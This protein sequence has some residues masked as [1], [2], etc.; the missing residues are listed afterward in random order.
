[1][2]EPEIFDYIPAGQPYDF[3][4][5][6]F[7]KLLE[8]GKPLYGSVADG[9]WQDIGS[10]GQYLAANRDVLDGKVE[11]T[12]PG[13]RLENGIYIGENVNVESLDNVTG[14]AVIG[15]Y[16][17]IDRDA[18]IGAYSVLGSNV[19]VKDHA[20]TRFCV[21]DANTYIGSRH[22]GSTARSSARTATSSRAPPSARARRSATSA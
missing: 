18:R 7:P 21:I 10:L 19:V 3:S 5:E 4:Q 15:N 22:Q 8:L 6:L 1:M 14:P 13:I 9:Y 20:E 17:K 16:A 11:A 2:L 12:I